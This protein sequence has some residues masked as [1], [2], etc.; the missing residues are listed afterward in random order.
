MSPEE[1]QRHSKTI[2]DSVSWIEKKTDD[3]WD[4]YE[5]IGDCHSEECDEE[6][7]ILRNS[8]DSY[9]SK[10]QKEEKMIDQYEEILH[11]KTG[12]K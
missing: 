7:E 1:L 9:L 4:R 2:D 8:M 11:N 5:E 6:R 12:I 10:L 3:I